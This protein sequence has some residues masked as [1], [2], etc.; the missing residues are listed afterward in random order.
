MTEIKSRAPRAPLVTW[1]NPTVRQLTLSLS[2]A[3]YEKIERLAQAQ[4]TSKAAL[5]RQLVEADLRAIKN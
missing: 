1:K 5:V 2:V 4:G 3:D